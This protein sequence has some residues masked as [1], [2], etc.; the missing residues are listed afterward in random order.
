[1]KTRGKF[2][3]LQKIKIPFIGAK[4]LNVSGSF[5]EFLL[6]ALITVLTPIV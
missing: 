2:S 6:L 4:F 3:D 5:I 1:M